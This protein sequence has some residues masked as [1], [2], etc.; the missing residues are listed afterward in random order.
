M[1]FERF[2][3]GGRVLVDHETG[4]MVKFKTPEQAATALYDAQMKYV[5][6]Q[7]ELGK[8]K[9]QW[10]EACERM[11]IVKRIGLPPEKPGPMELMA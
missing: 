2:Q 9:N 8:L 10:H 4:L 3:A 5:A 6:M 1:G 7:Y 11:L